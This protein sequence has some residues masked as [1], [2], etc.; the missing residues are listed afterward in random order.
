M[1][2]IRAKYAGTCRR[3]KKAVEVGEQVYW[4][5]GKGVQHVECHDAKQPADLKALNDRTRGEFDDFELVPEDGTV[6]LWGYG[7]YKRGSVLAGQHRQARLD[8]FDS[9]EEA[10]A[11]Y[12]S[13]KVRDDGTV[14]MHA[15][16]YIS[17][18]DVPPSDFDPMDAGEEW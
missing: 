15:S 12:P 2:K 6:W 7:T 13:V 16:H 18:P 3:C 14:N 1:K 11:A 17:L 5:T 9:L 8:S 4:A 10:R